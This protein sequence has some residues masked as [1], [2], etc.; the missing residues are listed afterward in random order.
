MA[1]SE[2]IDEAT[3]I[4]EATGANSAVRR[5]GGAAAWQ[6]RE[7]QTWAIA[8]TCIADVAEH[9]EHGEGTGLTV[10]YWALALFYNGLGRYEEAQVAAEVSTALSLPS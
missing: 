4:I 3:A 2:L 10:A 9:G 1:A 6:G 5:A 8:E 7:E